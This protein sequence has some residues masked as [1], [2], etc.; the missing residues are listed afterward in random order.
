[1]VA[2]LL[3]LAAWPGRVFGAGRVTGRVRERQLPGSFPAVQQRLSS[4]T[5]ALGPMLTQLLASFLD[6]G[7][8]PPPLAGDPQIRT[9]TSQLV[10]SC[11]RAEAEARATWAAM[12]EGWLSAEGTIDDKLRWER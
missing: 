1:M 2:A 6:P 8:R 12:A 9:A 7:G 11:L 4:W 3:P 5:G 10:D